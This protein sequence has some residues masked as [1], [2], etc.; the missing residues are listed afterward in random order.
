MKV[1][2]KQIIEIL[3]HHNNFIS[4][5]LH[6]QIMSKGV[7]KE[8]EREVLTGHLVGELPASVHTLNGVEFFNKI[9]RL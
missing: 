1:S 8:R 5:F 4:T 2:P 7:N 6:T 3:P 9:M